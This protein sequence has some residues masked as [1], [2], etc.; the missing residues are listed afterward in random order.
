MFPHPRSV[1]SV[2]F[3][4]WRIVWSETWV[5]WRHK[6][7]TCTP[8]Q[9]YEQANRLPWGLLDNCHCS[10]PLPWDTWMSKI[11]FHEQRTETEQLCLNSSR[12]PSARAKLWKK[13]T[14]TILGWY[15][16]IMTE[17]KSKTL[18]PRC[19]YTTLY[20][21]CWYVTYHSKQWTWEGN[22]LSPFLHSW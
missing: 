16:I 6:D 7:Q 1:H 9:R 19:R 8:I 18:R 11:H 12:H 4:H 3:Q 22:Y 5:G 14:P 10:T 2:S 13:R 20:H 15:L 21:K 17:V